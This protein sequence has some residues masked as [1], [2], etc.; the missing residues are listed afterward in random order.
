M[1]DVDFWL[2][3]YVIYCLYVVFR[4]ERDGVAEDEPKE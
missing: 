2:I 4:T 1:F 3:V